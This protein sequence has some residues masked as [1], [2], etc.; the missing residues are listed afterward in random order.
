MTPKIGL[1]E[2]ETVVS[3]NKVDRFAHVFT[4]EKKWQTTLE[5]LGAQGEPNGYGGVLYIVPKTW[6]RRPLSP[7][8]ERITDGVQAT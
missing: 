3:F 6:I 2:Q 4:Y 7:R 1:N 8:K 5:R